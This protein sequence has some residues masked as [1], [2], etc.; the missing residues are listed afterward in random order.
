M[1]L[2]TTLAALGAIACG[3]PTVDSALRSQ[4]GRLRDRDGREVLL[5]GVNARVEG[6]FDVEFNDGRQ[7][8]EEIP[9]FGNDDCRRLGDELGLDHL[10]LPINWSALEP[11]DDQFQPAY[12]DRILAVAA[13]CARYG[14]MTVVDFHQ[15]AFSKEIGEDGAPLWAIHPAP[16]MLL[17]GPLTDLAERRMSAQVRDAFTTFFRNSAGGW[18]AFAQAVAYVAERIDGQPGIVGLELFN[19]PVIFFDDQTL[20][21]F[22]RHVAASVREVAPGLAVFFEPSALRN[23]TDSDAASPEIGI[24]NAVYSPHVYT[25]VFE[26]GWVTEDVAKLDA[27]VAA[28]KVEATAH[29]AALYVGE[30]GHDNTALGARYVEASLAAFDA[31]R[32]SWAYWV[33][34]EWSQGGWGLYDATTAPVGRGAFREARAALLARAYPVAVD[35]DLA[36]VSYDISARRLTVGLERAGAGVH[37][38]AAP[39]L[40]YPAGVAVTCDGVAVVATRTGGRVRVGCAGRELVM[41]PAP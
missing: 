29:Q 4:Q 40:T 17:E 20:V 15:D 6:L 16:T 34:E 33:Y 9:P 7:K 11:E 23:I 37:E 38:L 21:G 5:R 3:Q 32:A 39:L 36:S 1:K 22:H 19:E 12:V 27:S 35:G 26:D 18:D 2:V 28:A 8:L 13:T 30:F 31:T 25:D 14:V 24:T 41:S 10:R